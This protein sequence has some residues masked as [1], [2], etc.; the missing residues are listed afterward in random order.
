[1]TMEIERGTCSFCEMDSEYV[2]SVSDPAPE[3]MQVIEDSV[4][5]PICIDHYRD[6]VASDLN[7]RR[8]DSESET[9]D[10]V[11]GEEQ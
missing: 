4:A 10:S 6:L 7:K 8:A 1:V 3:E 9:D 2:L 5:M 11:G